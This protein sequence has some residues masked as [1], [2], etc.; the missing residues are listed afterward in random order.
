MYLE[1]RRSRCVTRYL[2]DLDGL[3]GQIVVQTALANFQQARAAGDTEQ[4]ASTRQTVAYIAEMMRRDPEAVTPTMELMGF[5]ELGNCP[6]CGGV[7]MEEQQRWVGG[8]LSEKHPL[9]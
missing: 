7:G 1:V 5:F 9:D 6:A 3:C 2:S 8:C 4:I